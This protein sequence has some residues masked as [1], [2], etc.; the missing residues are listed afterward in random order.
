MWSLPALFLRIGTL[1]VCGYVNVFVRQGGSPGVAPGYAVRECVFLYVQTTQ[2]RQAKH[3][4]RERQFPMRIGAAGNE[5]R[6]AM[7]AL[8]S[9]WSRLSWSRPGGVVAG[10]LI[11]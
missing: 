1:W 6:R 3:K 2:A 8:D 7:V 4:V 9:C 11:D 5:S 10:C